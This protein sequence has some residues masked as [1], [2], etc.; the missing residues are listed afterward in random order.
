MRFRGVVKVRLRRKKTQHTLQDLA[1]VGV[2][3][4]VPVWKRLRVEGPRFRHD[5]AKVPRLHQGDEAHG[6]Q[7]R[8]GVG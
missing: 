8:V 2:L 4:L 3:S 7:D 1:G 6:P 5:G